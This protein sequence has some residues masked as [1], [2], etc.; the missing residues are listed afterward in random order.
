M[1]AFYDGICLL[2][3]RWMAATGMLQ[4]RRWSCPLCL[5]RNWFFDIAV[6]GQMLLA[7]TCEG[8]IAEFDLRN[9]SEVVQVIRNAAAPKPLPLW[10]VKVR[11][12][13]FC[14][15]VGG[16]EGLLIADL[17]HP[18]NIGVYGPS[19]PQRSDKFQGY[20]DVQWDISM[21]LLLATERGFVDVYNFSPR[22]PV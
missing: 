10:S 12:T 5:E 18:S 13:P 21:E 3:Q 4:F 17:S 22:S 15:A 16:S 9:T 6:S 7:V 8:I 19:V 2:L 14:A 1:V 11:D 20:K